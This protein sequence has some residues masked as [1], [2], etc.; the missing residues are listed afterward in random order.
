[1]QIKSFEEDTGRYFSVSVLKD[2]LVVRDPAQGCVWLGG[3]TS[4]N[5]AAAGMD[6]S[7]HCPAS[8][9]QVFGPLEGVTQWDGIPESSGHPSAEWGEAFAEIELFIVCLGNLICSKLSP[10]PNSCA[11]GLLKVN[12]EEEGNS[13]PVIAHAA[14]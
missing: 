9:H 10:R 14:S 3:T 5:R 8:V 4:P 2:V 11:G 6:T 13:R 7:G 12:R 1:M